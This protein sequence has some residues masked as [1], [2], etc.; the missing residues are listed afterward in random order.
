MNRRTRLIALA[1]LAATSGSSPFWG[2]PAL[3]R[4][5]WFAADRVEV[6]GSRLLAPHEVVAAS[7]VRI[8]D[9]VYTDPAAW[10]AALR[11]NPVIAEAR[12]ERRF[13]ATLRI[14]ITEKRPAAFVSAGTL[15]PATATGEIL[16]VDPARVPVD[17]P[18]AGSAP[19][20]ATRV[21]DRATLAVLAEAARLADADPMLMARVSEVRSGKAGTRLFMSAPRVEVL[22]ARGAA[23]PRLTQLRAA[24]ADVDRRLGA[25]GRAVVD[26]R[27]AD[28][29]VVRLIAAP[30]APS[31]SSTPAPA[32]APPRT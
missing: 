5:D 21:R 29:V 25:G 18:I 15:R 22:L 12:V 30:A 2:P 28:Q 4:V 27:F 31:T 11:R 24:L 20:T 26:A 3:R 14:R 7:G 32:P 10:E 13:P 19:D 8:G 6:A 23:E 9:N 17:L 1:A 16:P